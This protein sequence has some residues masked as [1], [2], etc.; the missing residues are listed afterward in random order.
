MIAA[1]AVVGLGGNV[2]DVVAAFRRALQS[3]D[4]TDGVR[5]ISVSS[6]LRTAPVGGPEQ[7]DFLNAA[8]LLAVELEPAE[9]LTVLREL[10][11]DEGRTR[12]ERW[13]PRT[14]DLDLLWWADQSLETTAL[15]VPHPGLIERRF[16][17]QPLVEVAP[18]ALAADGRR[19]ADI[20]STLPSEG[21]EVIGG[22]SLV[23]DPTSTDNGGNE[24]CRT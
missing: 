14:L 2:G 17:L 6:L 12:D 5:V 20:L 13:G 11:A 3:L 18:S 9:L 19:Y 1:P 4:Q 10:E 24:S 16:A 15:T 23:Y 7:D 8:V 21:V 22:P